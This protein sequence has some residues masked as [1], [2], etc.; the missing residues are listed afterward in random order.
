MPEKRKSAFLRATQEAQTVPP[1][2]SSTVVP[3]DSLTKAPL[4]SFTETLRSRETVIPLDSSNDTLL[5]RETDTP[6]SS[7]A[8]TPLHG[9]NETASDRETV[10]RKDKK[11]SIYLTAEQEDKL[12]DLAHQYKKTTGIRINRNHIVRYLID[13]CSLESLTGL[14][15]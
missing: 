10:T 13:H 14:E 7:S 8:R 1:S 9:S 4:D 15:R 6:S 11:T 5:S 3:Q 12:D 2:V